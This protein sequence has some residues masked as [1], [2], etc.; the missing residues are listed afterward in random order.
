MTSPLD[1]R[2]GPH[3]VAVLAAALCW[4]LLLSGGQ[5][6][7]YRVGMAVPDWPTTFGINMFVFNMWNAGW[8]VFIE[9]RH[10]LFGAGL[11]LAMVLLAVWFLGAE[12]RWWMKGLGLFALLA[13]IGQGLLG[14]ARVRLNSTSVAALHGC[15]G[16]AVFALLV[17]LCVLAGRGWAEG[18]KPR[19]DPDR[20]RRRSVVTLGLIYAQM[21]AGA[22]L[23][24]HGLGLTVHAILAGAVWGHVAALAWRVERKRSSVPEL[25][26]SSR[27]MALAATGQVALGIAAWWL[28]RP[29]DGV[30][31][32][33]TVLQALVRT[34]H[35]G[36]GALLLAAAMVLTLRAYRLLT[37]APT[38]ETATPTAWGLEIVA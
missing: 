11:G 19:P 23:R 35:V 22:L 28:L 6:T 33:V 30:P 16:Q 7:T 17:A 8:G 34:G 9:H 26:P 29:F 38:G 3:R 2:P 4:P 18:V 25:V 27:G 13:V 20:L 37:P 10:R 21:I 12:R 14:G 15:S 5:V 32:P 24:H 36:N 31:R 1:Y